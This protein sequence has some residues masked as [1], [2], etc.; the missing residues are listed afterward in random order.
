MTPLESWLL[1]IGLGCMVAGV[2]FL[3]ALF[4][5]HIGGLDS[6]VRSHIRDRLSR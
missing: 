2:E 3:I 1:I 6:E 5:R 4:G